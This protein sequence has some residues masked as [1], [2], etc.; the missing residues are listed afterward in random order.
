DKIDTAV[1]MG[2]KGGVIYKDKDWEKQLRAMLPV[3]RNYL[4]AVLDGA[5]G[6]IVQKSAKLLKAGGV[7]SIYGMTIAPKMEWL[8]SAVLANI[9]LRGSTLGSKREFRNMVAFVNKHKIVPVVSRIIKG[10]DNLEAIDGLFAE[11]EGG[12]QFG[13]L[14]IEISDEHTAARL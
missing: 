12:K 2:A 3:D 6:N 11:M 10:L 13:K 4:D 5:G 9:D 8:M 14:V 7:I 1:Q